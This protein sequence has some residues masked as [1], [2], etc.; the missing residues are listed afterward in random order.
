MLTDE[1][2]FFRLFDRSY[3]SEISDV[4][5]LICSTRVTVV[6]ETKDNPRQEEGTDA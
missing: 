2:Y 6:S 1:F 3:N 5:A 4:K